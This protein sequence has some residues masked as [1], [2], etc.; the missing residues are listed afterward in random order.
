MNN[1]KGFVKAMHCGCKE[2]EVNLKEETGISSRCIPKD[3]E[4][5][6]DKCVVCGK[7]A[8]YEVIWGKA[9]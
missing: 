2:C 6:S 3:Q 4:S 9:Y 8:K 1:K 5:L 7:P